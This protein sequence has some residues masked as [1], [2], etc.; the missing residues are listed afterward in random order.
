MAP[1]NCEQ[2]HTTFKPA[3]GGK[4]RSSLLSE[5]NSLFPRRYR[6]A[7]ASRNPKSARQVRRL[8][9]RHRR[10]CPRTCVGGKVKKLAHVGHGGITCGEAGQVKARL[11]EFER[12]RKIHRSMRNEVLFTEW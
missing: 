1:S 12:G 4:K 8:L 11:N 3:E 7:L 9:R 2:D 5:V 6:R 10:R